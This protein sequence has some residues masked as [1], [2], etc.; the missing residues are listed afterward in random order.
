MRLKIKKKEAREEHI[1]FKMAL[2]LLNLPIHQIHAL[3]GRLDLM[4]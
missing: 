1:S 4:A 2:N 3:G